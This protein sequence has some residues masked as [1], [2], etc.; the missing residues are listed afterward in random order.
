MI[1]IRD[2]KGPS[3]RAHPTFIKI[4]T[5][6][7]RPSRREGVGSVSV[8]EGWESLLYIMYNLRTVYSSLREGESRGL[9]NLMNAGWAVW[10]WAA[11]HPLA[12][13]SAICIVFNE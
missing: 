4:V 13:T 3:H 9:T 10:A 8:E 1:I 11:Y 7:D 6:C 5:L 2:C 12:N